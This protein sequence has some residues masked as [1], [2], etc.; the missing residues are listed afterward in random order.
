MLRHRG[1]CLLIGDIGPERLGGFG[2]GA[3]GEVAD[4]P[5]R[6]LGGGEVAIHGE[7]G[8]ALL[9]ETDRDGASV[10]DRLALG[11]SGTDDHGDLVG[12]PGHA[13]PPSSGA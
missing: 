12:H 5:A 4:H 11:L 6:L 3:V 2:G 10:A 8:R 13:G 7:D 9:G 1:A